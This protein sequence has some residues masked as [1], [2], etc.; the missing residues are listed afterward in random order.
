MASKDVIASAARQSH[1]SISALYSMRLLRCARNDIR[2]ENGH[3]A[4]QN[5]RFVFIHYREFSAA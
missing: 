2:Y 3:S 4:K 5:V 1:G